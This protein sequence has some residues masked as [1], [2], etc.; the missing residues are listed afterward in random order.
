MRK[1]S[2]WHT[3]T[4]NREGYGDCRNSLKIDDKEIH[5]IQDVKIE[6]G[7]SNPKPVITIKLVIN[8][9][10]GKIKSEAISIK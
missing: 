1:I 5:G 9:I 7:L 8:E 2:N 4:I 6:Y 10:K 3:V